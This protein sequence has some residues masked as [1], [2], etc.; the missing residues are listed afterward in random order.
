M[1]LLDDIKLPLSFHASTHANTFGPIYLFT[2][3]VSTHFTCKN[4]LPVYIHIQTYLHMHIHIIK[5]NH[6]HTYIQPRIHLHIHPH[7]NIYHHI[8]IHR[9]ILYRHIVCV[10]WCFHTHIRIFPYI[11]RDVD[12]YIMRVYTAHIIQLKRIQKYKPNNI[13]SNNIRSI[14]NIIKI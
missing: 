5:Y 2:I 7:T 8:H 6:T 11:Q 12:T 1:G 9:Q 10:C 3:Y 14:Y 13:S 4:I